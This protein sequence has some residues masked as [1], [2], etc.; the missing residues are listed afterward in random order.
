MPYA[1]KPPSTDTKMPARPAR[2][3][4][5]ASRRRQRWVFPRCQRPGSARSPATGRKACHGNHGSSHR[6]YAISCGGHYNP[7]LTFGTPLPFRE[8]GYVWYAQ[9]LERN[10]PEIQHANNVAARDDQQVRRRTEGGSR[11]AE[12]ARIHMAVRADQRESRDALI[13]LAGGPADERDGRRQ[14]LC[15]KGARVLRR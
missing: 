5:P 8:R 14:P 9:R 12:Q 10:A 6:K 4:F 1:E 15:A 11:V 13:K 2:A 3:R 7:H